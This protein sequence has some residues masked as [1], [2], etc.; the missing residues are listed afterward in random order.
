MREVGDGRVMS[1]NDHN[2]VLIYD[3]KNNSRFKLKSKF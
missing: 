3:L 1:G 2:T